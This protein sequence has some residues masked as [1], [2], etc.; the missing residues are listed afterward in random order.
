MTDLASLSDGV[1][2]IRIL[3]FITNSSIGGEYESSP[4]TFIH[5]IQNINLVLQFLT[6]SGKTLPPSVTAAAIVNGNLKVIVTLLWCIVL[7]YQIQPKTY[8]KLKG[9]EAIIQWCRD[10]TSNYEVVQIMD[11]SR[12]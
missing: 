1:V 7:E 9:I 12:W 10:C 3:E 11:F 2:F 6:N 8:Q 4:K 5:K